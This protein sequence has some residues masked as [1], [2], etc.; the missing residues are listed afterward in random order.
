MFVNILLD[1]LFLFEAQ[2]ILLSFGFS[3]RV[4]RFLG[5]LMISVGIERRITIEHMKFKVD[6]YSMSIDLQNIPGDSI[7]PVDPTGNDRI[8]CRIAPE[9]VGSTIKTDRN[10]TEFHRIPN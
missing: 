8:R 7:R 10:P 9:S 4:F 6:F 3:V 5:P 1:S 2:I